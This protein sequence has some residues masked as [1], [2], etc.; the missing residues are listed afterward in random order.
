METELIL[1][2][3]H[4]ATS[5]K[6]GSPKKSGGC[7]PLVLVLLLVLGVLAA[8]GY[9]VLTKFASGGGAMGLLA[10]KVSELT[11]TA[12]VPL[13]SESELADIEDPLIRKHLVKQ[14]SQRAYR[15][16]GTSSGIGN[17]KTVTETDFRSLTDF[18]MHMLQVMDGKEV[19]DIIIIGDTTYVKDYKDGAWWMQKQ[20]DQKDKT[21]E[22][23]EDPER[24]TPES[25]KE[26]ALKK[27]K[28][29]YKSLGQEACGTL[30]C[31]KYEEIGG[32]DSGKRTFWFDT[33]DLLL[34]REEGGFGEFTSTTEY[35]YDDIS[36]KAPSPTKQ[37]PEGKSIYEMSAGS[38]MQGAGAGAD[39]F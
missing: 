29:T 10:G 31:H 14:F 26:E 9:V 3:V 5:A 28:V 15:V 25:M 24:F 35:S 37:V 20:K 4:M 30:T 11:G 12:L 8:G 7:G 23:V 34:R 16:T 17:G 18:R 1:K 22:L 32:E 36:I 19:S 2:G 13:I 33:K 21:T 27:T 38:M 39:G 6:G